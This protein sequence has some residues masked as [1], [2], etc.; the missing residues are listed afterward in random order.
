ML[1]TTPLFPAVGLSLRTPLIV[2]VVI[3]ASPKPIEITARTTPNEFA[4][5]P[6]WSIAN[7]GVAWLPDF[8]PDGVSLLFSLSRMLSNWYANT[9]QPLEAIRYHKEALALFEL[10]NSKAGLAE[11][12]SLLGFTQWS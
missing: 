3:R 4:P 8:S 10:L 7:F 6:G 5:L 11:T 9:G 2:Y 1:S 12:L